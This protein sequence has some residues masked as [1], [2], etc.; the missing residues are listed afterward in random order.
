M[1]QR[2]HS[3]N[4]AKNTQYI[5]YN[6]IYEA[7]TKPIVQTLRYDCQRGPRQEAIKVTRHFGLEIECC[8]INKLL[9]G[10]IYSRSSSIN[11]LW[12]VHNRNVRLNTTRYHLPFCMI[13]FQRK[14]IGNHRFLRMICQNHFNFAQHCA[15]YPAGSRHPHAN[16]HITDPFY[17]NPPVIDGF[18]SQSLMKRCFCIFC[19]LSVNTFDNRDPTI[20]TLL[21]SNFSL[22]FTEFCIDV[23]VIAQGNNSN[24]Y[25]HGRV[26]I[27][28]LVQDCSNFSALEMELLQRFMMQSFCIFYDLSVNMLL[29]NCDPTMVTLLISYSLSPT[30]FCIDIPVIAQGNKS[31]ED[32]LVQGCSNFSAIA[33]ELLQS[34]ASI[35]IYLGG[36]SNLMKFS[37][38]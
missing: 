14:R 23:P 34:C 29:D 25:V 15:C 5:F 20:G 22:S 2:N 36:I 10:K 26:Y 24:E 35:D 21:I 8:M 38:T 16:C 33:M 12:D 1:E 7:E 17:G 13:S 4:D 19:D 3:T 28:G 9:H 6:H 27:H 30:E 18:P 37:W 32:G 31:N 11:M